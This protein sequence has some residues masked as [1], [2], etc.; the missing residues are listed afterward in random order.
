MRVS[1]QKTFSS[2]DNPRPPFQLEEEEEALFRITF[3]SNE[4]DTNADTLPIIS[5]SGVPY[6]EKNQK[7]QLYD[8]R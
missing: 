6:R 1:S 3:E 4:A 5:Q 7:N 2:G 8:Q